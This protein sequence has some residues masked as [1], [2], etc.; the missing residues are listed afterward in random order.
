ME[1]NLCSSPPNMQSKHYRAMQSL[2][3]KRDINRHFQLSKSYRRNHLNLTSCYS[4]RLSKNSLYCLS[5]FKAFFSWYLSQS[6]SFHGTIFLKHYFSKIQNCLLKL[7]VVK[8]VK[9][10]LV[11]RIQAVMAI[12]VYNEI[13]ELQL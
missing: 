9:L 4:P 2:A 13:Y 7:P 11:K 5:G 8:F 3:D 12:F 6:L 1:Q 10:F